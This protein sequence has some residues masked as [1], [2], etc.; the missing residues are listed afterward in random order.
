MWNTSLN[1]RTFNCGVR[2]VK[3]YRNRPEKFKEV[4]T[5]KEIEAEFLK[6]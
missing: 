2:F 5:I 4:F 1:A 3:A 6:K